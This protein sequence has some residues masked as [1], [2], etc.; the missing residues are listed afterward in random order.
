M[1]GVEDITGI[2]VDHQGGLVVVDLDTGN[3]VL[4]RSVKR[5]H[6]P[7]GC[8]VFPRGQRARLRYTKG[9]DKPPLIIEVMKDALPNS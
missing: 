4:C 5:L 3:Q 7:L 9:P 6:R 1:G 8:F 2:I